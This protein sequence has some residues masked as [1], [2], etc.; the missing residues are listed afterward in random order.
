MLQYVTIIESFLLI[1]HDT[2]RNNL[3][4]ICGVYFVGRCSKTVHYVVD[5]SELCN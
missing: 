1:M 3:N 5:G 2:R 4:K